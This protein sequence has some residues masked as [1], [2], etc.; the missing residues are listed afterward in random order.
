MATLTAPLTRATPADLEM[1]PDGEARYELIDGEIRE[2]NMSAESNFISNKIN[3]QVDLQ[4]TRSGLG[5]AFGEGCGIQ[6]FPE[7]NPLRVSDGAFVAAG[8]LPGD[9][10]PAT[11]YLRLAP[12]LVVEVVSPNDLTYEI[13]R[14]IA[15]YL[16]AGVRLVW[17]AHPETRLIYAYPAAAP[18]HVYGPEDDL[19]GGDVL[20]GFSVRVASLFPAP[21]GA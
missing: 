1:I 4:V 8:R 6:I 20:P 17:V 15:D 12:D 18:V 9:R 10:P 13:D 21:A 3:T 14:K 19:D 5:L 11:G 2:R 7:P 16:A